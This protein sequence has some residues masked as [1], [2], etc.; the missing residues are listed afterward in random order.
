M[1]FIY[2]AGQTESLKTYLFKQEAVHVAG[3]DQLQI[4]MF[5]PKQE[6]IAVIVKSKEAN[7]LWIKCLNL[8]IL[9]CGKG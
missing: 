9:L 1:A 8:L 5:C 2:V 7:G 6:I 3:F 4:T